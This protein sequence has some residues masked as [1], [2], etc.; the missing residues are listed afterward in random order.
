[1]RNDPHIGHM[2]LETR[3]GHTLRVAA[4]RDCVIIIIIIIIIITTPAPS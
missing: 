2:F 4:S 1:M 3:V